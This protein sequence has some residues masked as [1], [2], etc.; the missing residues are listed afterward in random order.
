MPLNPFMP[1]G[2]FHLHLH[3]LDR[4]ISNV[5]MLIPSFIES[6]LFNVN[7]EDPD[8]KPRSTASDLGLHCLPMSLIWD[9]RLK[10][11]RPVLGGMYSRNTAL[12]N[13]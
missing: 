11:V 2:F 3:S 1:N 5:R 6:S 13:M 7:S 4:S 8:Q 12:L 9:A 10:R